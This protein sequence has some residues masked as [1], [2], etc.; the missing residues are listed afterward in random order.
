MAE[1]GQ[2]KQRQGSGVDGKGI[3]AA[4]EAETS[5]FSGLAFGI[6]RC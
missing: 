3:C 6:N 4:C 5:C 1:K 2:E